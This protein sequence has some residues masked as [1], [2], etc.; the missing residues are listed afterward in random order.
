[1]KDV[2]LIKNLK[3]EEIVCIDCFC[4]EFGKII[5]LKEFKFGLSLGV[6]KCLV[7][8]FY[9]IWEVIIYKKDVVV[10][11]YMYVVFVIVIIFWEVEDDKC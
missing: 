4:F 3:D 7:F 1:M 9:L 10:L 11:M 8:Q 6:I 2:F 5:I